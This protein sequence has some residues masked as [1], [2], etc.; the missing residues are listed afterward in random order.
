MNVTLV[1]AVE[2]KARRSRIALVLGITVIIALVFARQPSLGGV[3][4]SLW[5]LA[6]LAGGFV[7]AWQGGVL[8]RAH[9]MLRINAIRRE[10]L[11]AT[12]KLNAGDLA[13]A[14]D[15]Y[16]ALLVK[17]QPLGAFHAVHVLMYGVARFCEGHTREGLELA[18]KAIDSG[19]FDQRQSRAVKD[20]AETW[21]VL[22]LL[23]AGELEKARGIIER[24]PEKVMT[25]PRIVLALAERD[26]RLAATRASEALGEQDFPAAGRPTAAALGRFAARK[27]GLDTA[28]FD[29]ELT[30]TPLGPLARKNPALVPYLPSE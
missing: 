25:T 23:Q 5:G 6:L 17:A 7:F 21:R 9:A 22:M 1:N 2:D 16:A 15:A 28:T 29:A 19:W 4:G 20:A 18:S 26:W 8:A 24:A 27:A 13:G 14:R 30:K 3:P 12:E 10:G 11:A